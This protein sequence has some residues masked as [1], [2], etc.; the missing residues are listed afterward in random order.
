MNLKEL[1][2]VINVIDF[3]VFN[4]ISID[5]YLTTAVDVRKNN[6]TIQDVK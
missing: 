1:K 2:K 4:E 3:D 6:L 5:T